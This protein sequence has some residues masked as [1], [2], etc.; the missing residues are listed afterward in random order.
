MLRIG[1]LHYPRYLTTEL[2]Y[3][4][5][6]RGPEWL[7]PTQ[8]MAAGLGDLLAFGYRACERLLMHTCVPYDALR[9]NVQDEIMRL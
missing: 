4:G 8:H 2:A 9:G 5:V 7:P 6:E 3:S 1:R